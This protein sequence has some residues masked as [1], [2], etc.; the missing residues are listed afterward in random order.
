M[1]QIKTKFIAD[2]AVTN[3]KIAAATID[4]TT[5]VTG[6]LP[7]L[8]GG[9]GVSA[10]T[11]SAAFDAL[12][13]M[14]TLGDLIIGG[15]LGTGTR[16][17]IGTTGQILSVVAGSPAWV[18]DPNPS[19]TVTSVAMSVPSFLS[20][21][22]SPITTSGTLAVTLSGT[23]LP[24]ANGGTGATSASAAFIALSPLTTAGDIIFED[25]APAPA[26]LAIGTSGQVLTV[27]AGLPAWSSVAAAAIATEDIITLSA[28]DITAQYVD[29]AHPALGASA[30]INS[31]SLAVV[32]GPEQLK[33]VDYTVS[34]TGGAGGVTRITFAGDLAT[35][36]AAALVAADILMVQYSY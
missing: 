22:G 23:A 3:A 33:A 11:A 4:L 2:L 20:V 5:K 18:T 26:R 6:A 28:G 24:I 34:L 14:T 16:L 31:I 29:L 27:V 36:G 21:S 17:G 32:G 7:L 9:T 13:P 12:S 8:N 1:A 30:S 15:A 10:A 25:S 35:G 19:G